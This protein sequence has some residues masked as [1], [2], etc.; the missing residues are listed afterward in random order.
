M[1]RSPPCKPVTVIGAE[2]DGR[3]L[4]SALTIVDPFDT[5][6]G[7][8][9]AG[10]TDSDTNA[11]AATRTPMK[12]MPHPMGGSGRAQPNSGSRRLRASSS[13]PCWIAACTSLYF[14]VTYRSSF[15]FAGSF[16]SVIGSWKAVRIFV[17][18]G[19]SGRI[20]GPAPHGA[21]TAI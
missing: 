13:I 5:T 4:V 15:A 7:T 12:R 9:P 8:A 20:A 2:G 16:E 11:V 21:D 10:G 3:L 14:L 6:I 19:I 17:G 18:N 1:P